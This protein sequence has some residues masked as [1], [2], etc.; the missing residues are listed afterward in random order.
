M[1][2]SKNDINTIL[3]ENYRPL[4]LIKIKTKNSTKILESD[5]T[6][7][8]ITYESNRSLQGCKDGSIHVDQCIRPREGKN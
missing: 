8:R 4:S 3:K 2:P 6:I 1:K 5:P 7:K